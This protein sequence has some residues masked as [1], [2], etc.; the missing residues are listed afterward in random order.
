MLWAKEGRFYRTV[1][2][3]PSLNILI[4]VFGKGFFGMQV[5][6]LSVIFESNATDA[7][8]EYVK[9]FKRLRELTIRGNPAITDAGLERLKDLKQLTQL[10]LIDTNVT[11]AG[12]KQLEL[13]PQP[14]RIVASQHPSN[15]RWT[16]SFGG[17]KQFGPL[18]RGIGDFG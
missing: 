16:E 8:L 7:D 1:T 18:V 3:S 14:S 11:D 2:D 5:I 15:R 4:D 12:L 13:A 9:R 17:P 10:K 6:P